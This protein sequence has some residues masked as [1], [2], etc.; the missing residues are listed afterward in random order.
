MRLGVFE[1]ALWIAGIVLI[2]VWGGVR[3]W[4]A[5]SARR[6]IAHFESARSVAT[7]AAP[8]GGVDL[9]LWSH[10]RVD[11]YRLSLGQDAG[12]AIGVLRIR[13]IGLE[14]PILEGT[15]E[16]TLDR[17]VGHIEGTDRP[18][19]RGNAGIA[20]HRDGFFH[21]L[22]DVGVGEA[23]ELDLSSGVQTYVVA[24]VR[25]VDP[26]EVS[27]LEPTGEP[28]ITLVTCYPFYFVGSAPRRYVVRAI[29][30]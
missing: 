2:A 26:R 10:S 28:S 20:G 13:K 5:W 25:I 1:R 11:H 30:R 27:V 19:G 15:D 9:A 23:V 6:D 3:A 18:G 7:A 16:L 17:G 4:G 14:V 8:P 29:R 24:E 21:G 12:P 22:K